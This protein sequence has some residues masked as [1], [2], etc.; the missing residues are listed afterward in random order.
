[1]SQRERFLAILV[2]VLV[3]G[4]GGYYF[5]NQYFSA[6]K[7]RDRQIDALAKALKEEEFSEAKANQALQR[8]DTYQKHALPESVRASQAFYQD[9]LRDTLE[10]NGFSNVSVKPNNFRRAG[11]HGQHS[12]NLSGK[13][14]L[15]E[16]VQFTYEFYSFN[17]LHKFTKLSI[18]P[19]KTSDKLD[20]SM[21]VAVLSVDGAAEV[22]NPDDV[23]LNQLTHGNVKD[24]IDKITTRNLFSPANKP[25]LFTSKT[26]VEAERGNSFKY[27]VSASDP[28]KD[29]KVSFYLGKEFPEGLELSESGSLNWTPAELGEY[30][31]TIE[32]RDN[33]TP[34]KST[35][36]ELVIN[37]KEPAP[38]EP[39]RERPPSFDEAKYTYLTGTVTVGGEPRAWLNNRPKNRQMRLA[40]G[41]TFTIGTLKGKVID[42]RDREVVIEI[43]GDL[44]LLSIGQ[45]VADALPMGPS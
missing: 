7:H 34:A 2:G 10:A 24:Y 19:S 44:R 27:R 38:V 39:P 45:P 37:V 17:V 36:Q 23:R 15:E 41:E 4:V 14:T 8:L 21:D 31:V 35:T 26:Q 12:F 3:L 13:A 20:I 11:N 22:P 33:R 9:R 40:P 1:M 43:E 25:P 18:H 16:L 5:M 6:I 29:D 30:K 42:V 32:A 28:D